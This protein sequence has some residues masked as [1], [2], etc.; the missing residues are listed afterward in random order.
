MHDAISVNNVE[1]T[2]LQPDKDNHLIS[3]TV[4]WAIPTA[5][6]LRTQND[7][8]ALYDYCTYTVADSETP[9][10][11]TL[12]KDANYIPTD[13]QGKEVAACYIWQPYPEGYAPFADPV[14]SPGTITLALRIKADLS[15]YNGGQPVKYDDYDSG[16]QTVTITSN[17]GDTL[18]PGC[19]YVITIS[20]RRKDIT[21]QDV[22]QAWEDGGTHY[23]PVKPSGNDNSNEGQ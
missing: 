11:L 1:V 21:L 5:F 22:Q 19:E 13:A 17:Y 3:G 23:L 15:W 6:E 8:N 18:M 7:D 10:T 20:F 4:P 16:V 2:L 14:Q 12:P 9:A